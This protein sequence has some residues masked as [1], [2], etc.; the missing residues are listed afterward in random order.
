MKL[1]FLCKQHTVFD[2][3][4]QMKKRI[5]AYLYNNTKGPNINPFAVFMAVFAAGIIAVT[6]TSMFPIP[7][8]MPLVLIF[9]SPSTAMMS[10]VCSV[11]TFIKPSVPPLTEIVQFTF[12]ASRVP[13]FLILAITLPKP[14][15]TFSILINGELTFMNT[16]KGSDHSLSNPFSSRALTLIS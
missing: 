1:I 7:N 2:V 6:F 16:G 8:I 13:I 3:F 12:D 14:P 4:Y 5:V 9:S 10:I 15:L 11:M